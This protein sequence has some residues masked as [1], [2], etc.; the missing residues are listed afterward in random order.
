[1][2]IRVFSHHSMSRQCFFAYLSAILLAFAAP[3]AFAASEFKIIPDKVHL[4][5]NFARAQL[6]V[7]AHAVGI[8]SDRTADLTTEASYVSSDPRVVS[9]SPT[10]ELLAA[11]NGQAT[12]TVRVAGGS[13][14]VPV[15]V[16]GVTTGGAIDFSD[17]VLP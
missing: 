7:E 10:G 14:T 16:T 2:L 13:Q 5:G 12:V 11:G 3:A 9:I 4:E 6:I 1:M 8:S 15:A 17:Q